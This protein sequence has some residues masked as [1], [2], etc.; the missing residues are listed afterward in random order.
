M[1]QLIPSR[2]ASG[3]KMSSVSFEMAF[4]LSSGMCTRVRMLCSRSASLTRITRR[5]RDMATSILR[6][7]SAWA[8]STLVKLNFSSLVRAATRAATS[9]PKSA[10]IS[11]TVTAVSSTV[12]CSRPAQT[13]AVS[14]RSLL[15]M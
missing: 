15:T 8:S 6:K 14:S 1:T 7:F 12:S 13:E 10:W 11:S 4:C 9:S 5:S 3:A 2:F